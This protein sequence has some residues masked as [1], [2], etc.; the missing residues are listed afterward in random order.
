MSNFA[1]EWL[2]A[3]NSHDLD[4][5]ME[6]YSENIVFY[7][8]FIKKVNNE[9]SGRITGKKA[10][11]E[12]FERALSVYTDLHFELYH[13]LEGVDSQVL[14]YKSVGNRLAAEMMVLNEDGK[15]TEVRAHYKEQ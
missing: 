7:S 15:I 3:W 10:L 12:Y 6:H 2:Q 11:R 5:I 1:N 8:P 14:Y 4:Q 9:V 13:V